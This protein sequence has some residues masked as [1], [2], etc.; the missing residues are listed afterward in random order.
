MDLPPSHLTYETQ[1]KL[2]NTIQHLLEQCCYDWVKTWFP[3][4]LHERHW[5]CAE[6]VELSK[7]HEVLS[8]PV[9]NISQ[10]A[11]TLASG[12]AL[13]SALRATL[14]LR[15]AA[16]HRTP[17]SAKAIEVMLNN[18]LHL[19][20][21]LRNTSIALRL[22]TILDEFRSNIHDMELHRKQLE[23]ALEG[24]LRDI[25]LQRT[26]LDREEKKANGDMIEQDLVNTKAFSR[27]FT[28]TLEE[29]LADGPVGRNQG[30]LLNDQG[31]DDEDMD[32]NTS[33]AGSLVGSG[34]PCG[35]MDQ[36]GSKDD[37]IA[38]EAQITP[39]TSLPGPEF[40]RQTLLPN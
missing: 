26:V 19:V 4:L 12:D 7:W 33:I 30:V 2:L 29:N 20:K 25:Q 40:L 15:N 34:S 13:I 27:L 9:K 35:M 10:E 32:E 22:E 17:T 37:K 36:D 24:K 21:A 23:N 11:T 8:S 14:P 39:E 1:H 3:N 31:V 38:Y 28:R 6:A 16:V 18:A 5:D